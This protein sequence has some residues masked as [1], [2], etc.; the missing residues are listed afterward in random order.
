[1]LLRMRPNT[2]AICDSQ[3]LLASSLAGLAVVGASGNLA[4][5]TVEI[6]DLNGKGDASAEATCD[7]LRA[8]L[9]RRQLPE[10]MAFG[11]TAGFAALVLDRPATATH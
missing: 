7:T 9:G 5:S 8:E 4:M 10:A 2:G 6:A 11:L 3:A 1:M